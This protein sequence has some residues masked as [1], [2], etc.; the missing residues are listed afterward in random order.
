[1]EKVFLEEFSAPSGAVQQPPVAWTVAGASLVGNAPA[2]V[3]RN[4]ELSDEYTYSHPHQRSRQK[5]PSFYL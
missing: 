1:M 3:F 4:F 5:F 2:C